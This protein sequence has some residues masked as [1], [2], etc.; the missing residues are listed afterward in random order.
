MNPTTEVPSWAMAMVRN[1]RN[2][3]SI[4]EEITDLSIFRA[5]KTGDIE[6][7]NEESDKLLMLRVELGLS[8]V[9]FEPEE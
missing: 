1:Y 2:A 8:V 5:L 9:G 3:A 6:L 4:P 7:F